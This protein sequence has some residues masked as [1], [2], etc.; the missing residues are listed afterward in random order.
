MQSKK[1]FS[2][3]CQKFVILMDT[4]YRSI[5]GGAAIENIGVMSGYDKK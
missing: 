5:F 4:E 2:R 3:Y 1:D